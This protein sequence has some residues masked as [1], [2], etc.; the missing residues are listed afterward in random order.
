MATTLAT[1][2]YG[3]LTQV[4]GLAPMFTKGGVFTESTRPTIATLVTYM[5]RISGVL[6]RCMNKYELPV[7]A[8]DATTILAL[9]LYVETEAIK[10]VRS[11]NVG[12][13]LGPRALGG[14]VRTQPA[15]EDPFTSACSFI[16]ELV[17]EPAGSVLTRTTDE[18]GDATFPIFQRS[19]FGNRFND[20]D[21]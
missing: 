15:S 17:Y 21:S 18:A 7:P 4:A 5:D 20:W 12:G 1:N 11:V 13:S 16:E 8:T 3:S 10:M 2:S 9:D 14:S 6:N 19:A